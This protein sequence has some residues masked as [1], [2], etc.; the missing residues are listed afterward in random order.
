MALG[1]NIVVGFAG[2]LD[3][4][5][6]AFFAIGAFCVG[7]FASGHFAYVNNEEGIHFLVGGN[8]ANL[9]GIHLNFLVVIVIAMILTAIAGVHHRPADA[10]A[11]R[12]LHRDRDAR[13]RRDHRPP[14]RQ[15]GLGEDLGGTP[16]TAGRQGI[17]PVDRIDLPFLDPFTVLDK[18]NWYWF[19]LFL[20][21]GR[22]VREL[23][24]ARLAPGPRVD[25]A[26]RGRGRR[27]GDGRPGGQDEAAGLRDGRLVRRHLG[28]VPGARC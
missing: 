6:V 16:V 9:P 28:R 1:L 15:P 27:G 4:G 18:A 8:A 10:A 3:L 21:R 20:V 12:R 2:L 19:A 7:W 14:R 25:R 11:A 23:P 5:Y 17:S 26:A 22:A 24:A 13:V